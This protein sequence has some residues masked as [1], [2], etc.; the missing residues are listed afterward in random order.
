MRE[1]EVCLTTRTLIHEH[2]LQ[3][4]LTLDLEEST[5]IVRQSLTIECVIYCAHLC[6]FC[7]SAEIQLMP[8][9]EY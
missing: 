1:A 6:D 7:A 3:V 9:R 4:T 8:T 2:E 5:G